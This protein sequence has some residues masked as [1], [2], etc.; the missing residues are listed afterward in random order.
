M[1][2]R[3]IIIIFLFLVMEHRWNGIDRGKQKNSRK[4]PVPVPLCPPQ[5]PHGL[6]RDRTRASA[7]GG[8]RLTAWA[9]ARPHVMSLPSTNLDADVSVFGTLDW[10]SRRISTWPSWRAHEVCEMIQYPGQVCSLC[11]IWC[12]EG[13][14]IPVVPTNLLKGFQLNFVRPSW[15]CRVDLFEPVFLECNIYRM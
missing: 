13:N 3:M 8:R 11:F 14:E 7:V 9:M 6:T 10:G 15:S 4:K 2:M 5:I 12:S 1:K